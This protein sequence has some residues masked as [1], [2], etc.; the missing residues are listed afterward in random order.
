MQGEV[1][2]TNG[3]AASEHYLTPDAS[4]AYGVPGT[5]AMGTY[6]CGATTSCR[7]TVRWV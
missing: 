5:P 2:R 3:R 6:T 1:T 4:H 7:V